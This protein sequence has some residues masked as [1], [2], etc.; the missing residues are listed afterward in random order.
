MARVLLP[1]LL[2]LAPA[3]AGEIKSD[4]TVVFFTTTAA[5]DAT[6][7]NW[8][9][10]VHGWIYEPERD[11][12]WRREV[13]KEIQE[14]LG[15]PGSTLSHHMSHLV[16]VGLVHQE[17]EGRVLRCRPDFALMDEVIRF[18]TEQCCAGVGR[19]VAKSKAV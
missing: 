10:P 4:E 12:G 11:S 17:R 16:N 14:H 8:I 3:A 9:V 13:I 2:L 5:P 7:A 15:I 1:L 18:L 19:P 6:G